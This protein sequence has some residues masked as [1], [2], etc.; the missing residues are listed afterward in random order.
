[1][2]AIE[3]HWDGTKPAALVLFAIPNEAE[4]RNDYE[5]A[6]PD[7]ASLILTHDSRRRCSR[8]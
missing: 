4:E 5:I 1:M 7:L 6:I 2:A 8:A 3:S